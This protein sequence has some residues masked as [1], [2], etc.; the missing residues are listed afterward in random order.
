MAGGKETPRQKMI[1][2]MYLVLTALLAMNVSS[3]V[4]DK[5]IFI[6]ASLERSV[7]EFQE[8][9]NN[10]IRR[11]EQTVEDTGN[12]DADV[13]LLEKAKKI[14]TQTAEV[15]QELESFK[16]KFIEIT[17]GYAEG[18]EGDMA[19]MKGKTDYDKVGHYMMTEGEGHGVEM[20]KL[21]NDYAKFLG[22]ET[23]DDFEK[24]AKGADESD[25]F[26]H[27]ANQKGKDF[28]TLFF[29]NTPTPAGVASV[30]E[31]QSE[32]M[33]Y[34]ARAL[35]TL[36]DKVGAG[37]L[38]FDK[39]TAMARPDAKVVAAGAKYRA[40]IFL[41]A[42][43]TV[44]PQYSM[45][46]RELPVENGFGIVEFVV[47]PP[48]GGYDKDNLATKTFTAGIT[49]PQPGGDTTFL[50]EQEYFVA[51]PVI[52]VQS[53]AISQLYLGCGNELSVQ[54][55][56]LG[57]G[58]NPDFRASGGS[59]IKG[60]G[61]GLVTIIPNSPKVALTVINDGNTIGTENFGVRKVPRPEIKVTA[62][63]QEID[64][65]QGYPVGRLRSLE[66]NAIPDENFAALLPK[67]A[68]YRVAEWDA[69]LAR[70]S[71]P[72]A[73]LTRQTSQR[74][75]ISSWQQKAR[76]GDRIVI[77]IKKVQR[78]NFR[79]NIEDVAISSGDAVI[80]IPLK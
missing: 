69:F 26:A 79:G 21:L 22:A 78:Q 45:G 19:H 24:I 23:G 39:I 3:T 32:V 53:Q 29:E 60:N 42:S 11:I 28:A 70:G 61:P 49:V 55:P 9:N 2:M 12:R 59:V 13:A 56:S 7:A 43:S 17:G 37:D 48:S 51:K 38:K 54:V 34:E 44:T 73:S 15:I 63:G 25:V 71:A 50:L 36:A 46:G 20:E 6:N 4:L 75:D 67:D 35:Q 47:S 68:R 30:S 41:A 5:F 65:K 33:S 58:Y 64:T 10:T 74:I 27:D 16:Q 77:E 31:L 62:R 66:A 72:V 8:K 76:P 1:G 18:H 57:S 14:R 80:N 40:E 52:Q